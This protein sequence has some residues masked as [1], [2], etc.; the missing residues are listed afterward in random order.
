M[1]TAASQFDQVN[2]Q[3]QGMLTKLMGEL[4]VLES[5]WKGLGA[6]A[7]AQVKEQYAADQK[8]LSQALSE[9][10]E[11]IRTSGQQYQSTDTDAA[12]KLT[13]SGGSF[14]LPL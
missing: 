4:Q 8:S 6:Q 7:F 1:A 12:S 10:A 2:D 3:L 14:S 13:N 11:S 9:T 5:T